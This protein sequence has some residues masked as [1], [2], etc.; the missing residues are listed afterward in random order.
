MEDSTLD[1]LP[2]G[3]FT[4]NAAWLTLAVL[5]HN[6]THALG[7]LASTFHAKARTG[8]VRR[9]LIGVPAHL[10]TSARTLTWH[11]PVRW[12]WL[13]AL[14]NLRTGVDHRPPT[15]RRTSE[16][17]P[18]DRPSGIHPGP[19][20][21]NHP[22]TDQQ[23]RSGFIQR[24]QAQAESRMTHSLTNPANTRKTG[25]N[26]LSMSCS[27]SNSALTRTTSRR[28]SGSC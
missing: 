11:F 17:P 9:H 5:A 27:G 12:P 25:S 15:T 28:R 16:N 22:K 3:K 2:S 20:P 8:T 4:A 13:R 14:E 18:P 23:T 10:A 6:L 1:H 24:T 19:E 26:P 7:A 21:E